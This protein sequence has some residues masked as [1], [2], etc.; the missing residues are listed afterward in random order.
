MAPIDFQQHTRE[1]LVT[2][3]IEQAATLTHLED[4]LRQVE[5]E[6][7]WLREQFRLAQHRQFGTSSE[8]TPEALA[9]LL[10]NEVEGT[11]TLPEEPTE[12]TPPA[13]PP[14]PRRKKHVGQREAL[15]RHVPVVEEHY[16][17]PPEEQICACCGGPLHVMGAAVREELRITPAKAELVKQIREIYSCRQCEH[18][19]P[20]TPVVTAPLPTPPA[21]PGSLAS[22]SAVAFFL[23]QK[24]GQGVPLYRQEQAMELLGVTI[25]RQTLANWM[26]AGADWLELLYDHLHERLC[27]REVLHADETTVQVLHEAGRAATTDSYMWVYRTGPRDGPAIILYDYQATRAGKHPRHF[28]AHFTG[29]LQ[30]DAYAG[31]DAVRP[32]GLAGYAAQA[33][34]LILV[35]CWA[36]ARRKFSEA[37]IAVPSAQRDPLKPTLAETGLL[38]CNR[39]FK[40]EREIAACSSEERFRLR[41][42]RSR[43]VLDACKAWLDAVLPTVLPKSA[44]GGA[45]GYCLNQWTKLTAFLLDGRLEL[46]NNA[47]ERAVKPFVIGRKNWLFANTPRGAKASAIIYSLVE[48]AKANGVNP[49]EYLQEVLTRLPALETRRLEEELDALLPWAAP[50]QAACASHR[51]HA[52]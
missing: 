12:T 52:V 7:A 46:S 23:W 47:D 24:Y 27:A 15:L 1:D 25:S 44:L 31:Y 42:Q 8:H 3:C 29:Y 34:P 13:T 32:P 16:A 50:M 33:R 4:K 14:A 11:A 6:N 20:E 43:P 5:G 36:H 37:L 39:L 21:F 49:Y 38:Y 28:L 17:L 41:L 18:D 45:I 40:I 9:H 48:T 51:T 10:F 19:A 2:T 22:P 30:V 35:G 26:I